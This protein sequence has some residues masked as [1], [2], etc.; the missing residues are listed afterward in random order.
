M[1]DVNASAA[2]LNDLLIL[3]H[4]KSAIHRRHPA[5]KLLLTL[6]YIGCV[7]SFNNV[8]AFALLPLW[9]YPI[10]S[11]AVSDTPAAP[12]VRRLAVALP[13]SLFGAM[14]N[15]IALRETAL[16]I[17][18]VAVSLGVLSAFTIVN[19]ALMSVSAA[20]LLAAT[21]PLIG[22]Q[23]QLLRIKVPKVLC[24][25]L[26]LTY[27]YLTTLFSEAGVMVTAYKLR[28][29]NQRGIRM[30][31]MGTF[32]GQLLLRSFDRAERVYQ[33]MLLRGFDGVYRAAPG[34]RATFADYL[35]AGVGL[36]A[37][38]LYRWMVR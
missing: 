11:M 35:Y 38:L 9:S 5:A 14:Y 29:P 34:A 23:A 26:V 12:I 4:G 6:G 25:Q 36:A 7:L 33:A 16:V 27:R 15:L 19:K 24:L 22:I 21:T 17:G 2:R 30:R 1:P 3:S 13:F 31:D 37:L 32:V 20:V 10:L 28:A 18:P 8:S